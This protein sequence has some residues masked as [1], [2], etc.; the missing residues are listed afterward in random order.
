MDLAPRLRLE[1]MAVAGPRNAIPSLHMAWVLL[2]WWYSRGL[3]WLERLIVLIFVVFTAF[4]TLGTGEHWF[5]DLMVA[6]PFAL[7]I[8][9]I[10]SYSVPWKDSRRLAAF[11]FGLLG[12]IGWLLMLRYEAKFFWA[13]PAIPWTLIAATVALTIIRQRKLEQSVDAAA[14]P[15]TVSEP[16]ASLQASE[17]PA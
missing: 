6:F 15:K 17:I 16:S 3:S 1:S 12:T 11:L 4:A 13:S 9:A 7:F 10:A 14:F 2:A 8:Q 5:I